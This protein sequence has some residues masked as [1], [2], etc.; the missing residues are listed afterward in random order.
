MQ[1]KFWQLPSIHLTIDHLLFFVPKI[2]EWLFIY[3]FFI[4]TVTFAY[5]CFD[6]GYIKVPNLMKVKV[7]I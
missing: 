7:Q 5:V 1:Q 6:H 3:F 2:F 4:L